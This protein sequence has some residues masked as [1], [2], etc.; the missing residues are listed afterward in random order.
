MTDAQIRQCIAD[1]YILNFGCNGRNMDV[2][3][4]M[5]DL[6]KTGVIKTRDCSLSQETRRE[7]IRA[8]LAW[9]DGK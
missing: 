3:N 4:L 8:D 6:E 2:M 5:A 9:E 1:G 7:A